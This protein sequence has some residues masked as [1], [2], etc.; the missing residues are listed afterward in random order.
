MNT[1][2]GKP[3]LEDVD[4]K[5]K[6]FRTGHGFKGAKQAAFADA[7]LSKLPEGS[8][9]GLSKLQRTD[10]RGQEMMTE[11]EEGEFSDEDDG[12]DEE[13]EGEEGSEGE[14]M[15]DGSDGSDGSAAMDV[16]GVNAVSHSVARV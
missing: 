7:I 11:D 9:I 3:S 12:E 15:S 6:I 16:D 2:R 10:S 1:K 14:G 13:D 8:T 4:L 5:R